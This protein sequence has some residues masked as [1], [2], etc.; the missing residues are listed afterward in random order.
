MGHTA[1]LPR[2]FADKTTMRLFLPFIALAI[3]I[4]GCASA[5]DV[6]DE[7]SNAA[8]PALNAEAGVP[9]VGTVD[10]L[11]PEAISVDPE[12]GETVIKVGTVADIGGHADARVADPDET[13]DLQALW[14]E[15]GANQ[16]R[17]SCYAEF[18]STKGW[19]PT[20]E[21]EIAELQ[22]NFT[23]AE[24]EVFESC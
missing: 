15:L 18:F 11:P 23:T 24:S 8:N 10:D 5:D 22:A 14:I 2:C 3:A 6:A 16:E 4:S 20:T 19:A 1:H 17:A 13:T 7:A 21:A 9:S 12:T